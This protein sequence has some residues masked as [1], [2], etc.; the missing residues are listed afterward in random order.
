VSR[1]RVTGL[2]NALMSLKPC[3]TDRFRGID[4]PSAFLPSLINTA[5]DA[6]AP[7]RLSGLRAITSSDLV[8]AEPGGP[9][10]LPLRR[11]C[12]ASIDAVYR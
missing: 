10:A 8:A 2:T 1:S 7:Q 9:P 11:I 5:R 3:P 12:Q 6:D 4:G